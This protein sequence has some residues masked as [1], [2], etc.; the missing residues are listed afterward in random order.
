VQVGHSDRSSSAKA[1]Y[2]V[3]TI[4]AMVDLMGASAERVGAPQWS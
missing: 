2:G 3:M 4:L 1:A